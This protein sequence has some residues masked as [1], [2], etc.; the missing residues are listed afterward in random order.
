MLVSKKQYE[1]LFQTE[2]LIKFN[3]FSQRSAFKV[4]KISMELTNIFLENTQQRG[5]ELLLSN[6]EE[7]REH[8]R[9]DFGRWNV[10]TSSHCFWS[11]RSSL[12]DAIHLAWYAAAKSLIRAFL[13]IIPT[14]SKHQETRCQ[15]TEKIKILLQK[16]SF[17]KLAADKLKGLVDALLEIM[18]IS[19]NTT[20]HPVWQHSN[21]QRHRPYSNSFLNFPGTKE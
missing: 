13:L 17:D 12:Q 11:C 1:Y 9:W 19:K 5:P 3:Q 7:H 10:P 16:Q 15:T 18:T 14:T 2:C 21:I 20:E 6:M 8:Y 4:T